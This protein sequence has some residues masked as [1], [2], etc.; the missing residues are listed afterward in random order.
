MPLSLL[1]HRK[2]LI[3]MA[4]LSAGF[5]LPQASQAQEGVLHG[6]GWVTARP[7]SEVDGRSSMVATGNRAP[8][9]VSASGGKA[10]AGLGVA[11]SAELIST[12]QANAIGLSA[13]QVNNSQVGVLQN[14]VQGFVNAVGGAATANTVL[15]SGGTG[16]RPF[17]DSRMLLSGNQTNNIEAI[18]AKGSIALGAIGSLQLPGRATANSVLADESDLRRAQ[19][20]LTG[21]RAEGVQSIGGAALA[22]ATTLARSTVEDLNIIQGTNSARDVRAGGG[23][24]GV[25]GGLVAS[26][27]L[28]GVAA[29][30]AFVAA[31]SQVKGA[32]VT[33][34]G[35]EVNGMWALG[36]S[37]LA[38]SMSLADYTGSELRQYQ[39]LQSGNRAGK[40][41][42]SGGSGSLLKGA[43]ADVTMSASAL[44]NSVSIQRGDVQGATQHT[45]TGNSADKVQAVGGA[46]A[47]NSIWL[48][49]SIAQRSNV[50]ISGNT[51]SDIDTAG[52]GASIGGGA[53]G[54]F[55]RNGRALANSLAL[56]SNATL[57]N[58]PVTIS[59]N[60][61][62]GVQGSGGLST[63]NSALLS[64]ARMQ[65]GTLSITGNT[66]DNVRANGFEGSVG[67]GLLFSSKQNAM[68]LVNSLGS[69]GSTVDAASIAL[70][71]NSGR[72]LSAQGGKLVANS[73]SVEKGEGGGSRLSASVAVSGN[74]AAQV[75]T[76]ASAMAGPGHVFSEKSV[77]RAATN[78]VVLYENV[79]IDAGSPVSVAGNRASRVGAIGGTALVNALAGYRDS[80]VSGSPITIANNTANDVTTGGSYNQAAGIGNAKN[81]IL[82]ANGIYLEGDNGV[83]LVG[84]P[85]SILGNTANT[86][87]ADGGRV[88]ANAVALN[89]S[90]D[91]QGSA[92]TLSNNRAENVTSRGDEGTFGGYAVIDRGV[93]HASANA[94]QILGALRASSMQL[95]GN[96]AANVN[97]EKGV[98]LANSAVVDKSGSTDATQHTVTANRADDVSTR[99]GKTASANSVFNEGAISGSSVS[100]A[101]NRGSAQASSGDAS[102][103][104]VRNREGARMAGIAVTISG[105]Q[106]RA[107]QK[108]TVNS[109]DNQGSVGGSNITVLGNQGSV[110]GGA[111]ANSVINNGS[112]AGSQIHILGNHGTAQGN[113]IVNSVINQGRVGAGSIVI[114]GNT[115]SAQGGGTVNS[116]HNRGNGNMTNTQIVISGNRGNAN[117]GGTV[118]SVD[119]HGAMTGRI[120]ILGNQGSTQGGGTVN[121]VIN[122]GVMSGTIVISGNR[123]SAMAGGT[124]NSV[125]NRGVITGSVTIVGNQSVAGAGM[126]SGSVRTTGG[127]VTGAAGVTGNTPWAAN[128]GLTITKPSTGV[129][130][131]TVTVGPAV[132]VLS[133]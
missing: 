25:G 14:Q 15:L 119:N 86:L 65:N 51:A 20:S 64:E 133:M 118:N 132:T 114:A 23:S 72:D 128:P 76:G 126:T 82:V 22:N 129:V 48:Q 26:A 81:G 95:L 37:A 92:I 8:A 50:T 109:V 17:A 112:I 62:R 97:A 9:Q 61:A 73:V 42:A 79:R 127:V 43:L 12:A 19:M 105:N 16:R 71:G 78:A 21:N 77:A 90:G 115:G 69:F 52:G 83:R 87:R 101:G 125:V 130:N 113:G 75:S 29:A 38:N 74:T 59:G 6:L 1:Q 31:G 36:G 27:D 80:S 34:Q 49:A 103:N 24:G 32:R 111:I 68:A 67:G 54:A 56:D 84:S 47:A 121:S 106:G 45:L 98:A 124:A 123:G 96:V 63:A 116:V 55:E 110:E 28:S 4:V 104:S 13:L 91:M 44:A 35:N 7:G 39:V 131:R 40:V 10:G 85:V 41:E 107:A 100:I 122:R 108:G 120:A 30:N 5:T 66:A 18:G 3:A 117:G 46:A 57:Q 99:D 70:S 33:Q 88:N 102:A 2:T 11:G 93:G 58:T 60:T 53:I 94:V 89:G